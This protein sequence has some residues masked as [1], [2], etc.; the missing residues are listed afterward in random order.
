M[1]K[2]CSGKDNELYVSGTGKL[3]ILLNNK[4]NVELKG[5]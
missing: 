1:W 4:I 2:K 3:K 5:L